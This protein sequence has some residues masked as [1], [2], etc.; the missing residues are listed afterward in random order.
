MKAKYRCGM[1][2]LEVS[3]FVVVSETLK[4]QRNVGE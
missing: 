4:E 3:A 1:I 2:F